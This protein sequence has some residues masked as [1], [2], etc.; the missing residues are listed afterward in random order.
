MNDLAGGVEAIAFDPA[1]GLLTGGI[2]PRRDGAAA[3]P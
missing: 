3:G 1:T 2:D